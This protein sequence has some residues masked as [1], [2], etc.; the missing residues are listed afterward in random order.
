MPTAARIE[1]ATDKHHEA[2]KSFIENCPSFGVDGWSPRNGDRD[3]T[4][5]D[6]IAEFFSDDDGFE[7]IELLE[8][9]HMLKFDETKLGIETTYKIEKQALTKLARTPV[10]IVQEI[11][12]DRCL[13]GDFEYE[14]FGIP[15]KGAKSYIIGLWRLLAITHF[16]LHPET[17]EFR[18]EGLTRAILGP[19]QTSSPSEYHQFSCSATERSPIPKKTKKIKK[20]KKM[21]EL[22][23]EGKLF[24]DFQS[25]VEYWRKHAIGVE[26]EDYDRTQY[27]M[28][29]SFSKDNENHKLRRGI[30]DLNMEVIKAFISRCEPDQI[31]E[32]S[33]SCMD[34]QTE[35]ANFTP[36]VGRLIA[37]YEGSVETTPFDSLIEGSEIVA[38]EEESEEEVEVKQNRNFHGYE[39]Y[40][41]E[42]DSKWHSV[43]KP[44]R[45][46]DEETLTEEPIKKPLIAFLKF[47]NA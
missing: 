32:I 31:K 13:I 10:L 12:S 35:V 7:E 23:N 9:I 33:K 3:G 44:N 27:W 5:K 17:D 2:V 38:E 30:L 16:A 21:K 46:W 43:L 22:E 18:E 36:S 24:A 1:M 37:S 29:Q 14:D 25:E 42:S 19:H 8:E 4:L 34:R 28:K 40:F 39:W 41:D 15:K 6:Y 45:G 47:L 11:L 26:G 20:T